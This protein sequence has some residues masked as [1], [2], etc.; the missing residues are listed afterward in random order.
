[1]RRRTTIALFACALLLTFGT[2]NAQYDPSKDVRVELDSAPTTRL[3]RTLGIG[4]L[5][6]TAFRLQETAHRT[7]TN[8]TG[9]SVPYFYVWVCLGTEC[10]PVDPFTVGN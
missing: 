8:T 7:L 9:V 1:M 10:V 4:R 2:G 6:S 5:G 3:A